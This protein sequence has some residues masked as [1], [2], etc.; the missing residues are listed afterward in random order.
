MCGNDVRTSQS[1]CSA[2]LWHSSYSASAAGRPGVE[3]LTCMQGA[4]ALMVARSWRTDGLRSAH[5]SQRARKRAPCTWVLCEALEPRTTRSQLV[6][7]CCAHEHRCSCSSYWWSIAHT[8]ALLWSTK[9]IANDELRMWC[10]HSVQRAHLV[11]ALGRASRRA[12]GLSV[13]VCAAKCAPPTPPHPLS[14]P[15]RTLP[16]GPLAPDFP[17]E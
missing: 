3:Q 9:A 12:R 2:A 15:P 16:T 14:P 5:T 17:A 13:R 11:D 1:L 10:A 6:H 4:R 8:W 7:R